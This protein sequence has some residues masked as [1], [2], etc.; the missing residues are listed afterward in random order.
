MKS[1]E[2]KSTGGKLLAEFPATSYGEWHRLVEGELK[3]APFEKR[4]FATT[5]EGI[6]L[7]PIYRAEESSHL[8]HLNSYP[9]F[10]PFVRGADAGGNPVRPWAISQEINCS[11][12][13]EFNHAARNSLD[14][15]LNA[16]NIVLDK[17]TR[18]GHDPDWAGLQEVGAAGLSIASVDDLDRALEGIDLGKTS[19]FVRSGASAMPFAALLAALAVRRKKPFSTLR[20]CVEMDPLGVLSHE[21]SLPQSLGG[22]YAEMAALLRWASTDAPNLQTICVHSRAWHEAGGHAAQELAFTL[23]TGVEYLREMNRRGLTTNTTAPR[24]RFAITVGANFFMEIAK[25]RALR[26]IWARAVSVA[27]GDE[28]AQRL[29]AHVRTAQWNKTIYDPYN[30]MLR[31]TVEAVAGVIGG[32]DSMQVG[33]FDEVVRHPDYFSQRIARNTQV[34]LQKECHLGRVIDPA[35]G[36]WYVEMLT[37]DLANRAWGLFQEVEKLG[38]MEAALRAGFPQK[39]VAATAAEKISAV[40]RRRDSIVG[41]NQYANP[42]EKPLLR[43]DDDTV[44]FYKRRVW[45][46]TSHRTNL[47]DVDDEAVLG[48]LTKVLDAKN[49]RVFEACI[50]AASAGATLGE[51]A[52]AVRIHDSPCSTITPVCITR[53]AMGFEKL[54]AT[55][56][57][58]TASKNGVRPSVFLCNMGPLADYKARADFSRGFFSVGGYNVI[59]PEGFDSPAA[60]AKA[61]GESKA[62]IAVICSTDEKYPALVPA[63]VEAIRAQRKD[64]VLVL[65]GLPQAQIEAHKKA[66]IDEF[67]H[68]RADALELL[69]AFHRRIGVAL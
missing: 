15:G 32:C 12:P 31:A 11:S 62:V 69:T 57:C 39:A 27:G 8:P 41:L 21:G 26:M 38:G 1:T 46:V 47:E 34:I 54:R 58:F 67:I 13:T 68:V 44:A 30:N 51:I 52:R 36:S 19:L 48:K 16:L 65:A 35:G 56:D 29:T 9:G 45:Q 4:M 24:I 7:K 61:F 33:A 14:S 42:K 25:L 66:G 23:A 28:T 22:A 37:S 18:N 43:S 53:V 3:G 49:P 50:E 59:S 6:T 64:A 40:N 5:Y 2:S 17:A 55:M 10:A 63:L 60:A 20:G